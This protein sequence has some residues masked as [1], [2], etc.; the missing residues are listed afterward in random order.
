MPNSR[1]SQE[2]IFS[3][4]PSMM[5]AGP[6]MCCGTSAAT[7]IVASTNQ[8]A[9]ERRMEILS[10]STE[11]SPDNTR[12]LVYRSFQRLSTGELHRR[13]CSFVYGR[14]FIQSE[15]VQMAKSRDDLFPSRPEEIPEW[16]I[17][18]DAEKKRTNE[19]RAK[20]REARLARDARDAA[21]AKPV[22]THRKSRSKRRF[23]DH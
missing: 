6:E 22:E 20:L 10:L 23:R 11:H 15:S 13:A 14:A 7:A 16:Q 17:I 3:P 19:N 1:I 8:Q 4:S 5:R 18:R 21:E 2:L 9:V 12:S